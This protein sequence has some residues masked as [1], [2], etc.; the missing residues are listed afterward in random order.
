MA[1]GSPLAGDTIADQARVFAMAFKAIQKASDDK[2]WPYRPE[3]A[4]KCRLLT[5]YCCPGL[6]GLKASPVFLGGTRTACAISSW[7]KFACEVK[8]SP[9][10][11]RV[12]MAEPE[13]GRLETVLLIGHFQY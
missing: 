8:P 6:D 3:D 13:G 2:C 4:T 11:L 1:S 9:L 7:L 5:K 12:C 10:E